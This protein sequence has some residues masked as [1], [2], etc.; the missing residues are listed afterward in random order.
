MNQFFRLPRGAY[1]RATGVAAVV[2]TLLTAINQGDAILAGHID[3]LKILLTYLVPFC[4]SVYSS[5]A[6]ATSGEE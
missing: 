2:G 4:V 6:S 5:A 3:V 1:R